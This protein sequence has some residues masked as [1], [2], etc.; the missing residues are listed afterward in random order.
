MH[1][2]ERQVFDAIKQALNVEDNIYSDGNLKF[3]WDNL[4]QDSA[5]HLVRLDQLYLF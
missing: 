4:R 1:V 3:S 5:K 2:R